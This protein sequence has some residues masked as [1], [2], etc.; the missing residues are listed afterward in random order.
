MACLCAHEK[1]T[2]KLKQT[3]LN[4]VTSQKFSET[5]SSVPLLWLFTF[6]SQK[7]RFCKKWRLSLL[8]TVQTPTVTWHL[9]KEEQQDHRFQVCLMGGWCWSTRWHVKIVLVSKEQDLNTV[10]LVW[11]GAKSCIFWKR[12]RK[13]EQFQIGT[14]SYLKCALFIFAM[15]NLSVMEKEWGRALFFYHWK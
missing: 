3:L 4:M 6:S 8:K 10:V 7:M 9:L 11:T 12:K 14:R 5:N 15:Q 13:E 1:K 2:N